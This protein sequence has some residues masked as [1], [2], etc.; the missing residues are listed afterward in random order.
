MVHSFRR[1]WE[2]YPAD[3]T[4]PEIDSTNA[5]GSTSS[6]STSTDALPMLPVESV[7]STMS[8]C[9]PSAA[10]FE[11]HVSHVEGNVRSQYY[12]IFPDEIY[13]EAQRGCSMRDGVV[14]ETT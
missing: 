8:E 6:M 2:L 10:P 3:V 7:A 1:V 4:V 5:G 9:T 12:A 13:Q 11:F 14:V